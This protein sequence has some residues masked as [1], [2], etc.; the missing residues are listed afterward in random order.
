MNE[1][2]LDETSVRED[3][4]PFTLTR[5]T[6][7]IRIGILTIREKWEILHQIRIRQSNSAQSL[8]PSIQANLLP[9]PELISSIQLG[10]YSADKIAGSDQFVSFKFPWDIVRLNDHEIR[11]DFALLTKG[12]KSE[13]IS[14]SNKVISSDQVFIEKGAKVEY[15]ILNASTGPIYIGK[16]AE[17][18]EG[19]MIRGPFAACE[20]SVVKMGSKIYGATTIGPYSV[21][22]GEIKNSI[23]FSYSNKAHEGYLGDSVIGS[24]CNL[25]AGS[26]NSN[27][28]NNG[29]AVKV[30]NETRKA[31]VEAGQKCGLFMGDYSRSAINSSFNTGTVVGVCANVFGEGLT[32]KYIPSFAWGNDSRYLWEKVIED[33]SAW[34]KM[35][36]QV[37]DD[38]EIRT[39]KHIFDEH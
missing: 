13:S 35:K 31:Y 3:L 36:K 7:D 1:I 14:A 16:D 30:W 12:R 9:S 11:H 22:G 26:S 5:E 20:S 27:L 25:G 8:A 6:A 34:K 4:F 33:L 15:A 38:A 17:I 37:L 24:W 28:K 10:E 21:V 19:A 2:I 23:L 32:A 29:G 18:M 39:L